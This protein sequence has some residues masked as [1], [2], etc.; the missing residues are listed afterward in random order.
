MVQD[1]TEPLSAGESVSVWIQP[2]EGLEPGEYDD[3]ITYRTEEGIE[4]SFE[5]KIAVEGEDDSSDDEDLKPR[6]SLLQNRQR[7]RMTARLHRQVTMQ[8]H[9][10]RHSL[11][12]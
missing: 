12:T 7:R 3:M 11:L 6:M 10:L 9:L 8:M 5:A 2:R 4:V 1:I